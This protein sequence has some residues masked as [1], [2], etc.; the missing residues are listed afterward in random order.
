[1]NA[2][3]LEIALHRRDAESYNVDLRFVQ[4]ESDADVRPAYGELEPL[5]IDREA[6]LRATDPTA[7]GHVLA[8][9]LF[10]EAKVQPRLKKP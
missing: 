7:Q 8:Q 5:R 6:L 2:V 9:A 3:E 1:M 4:P 10:I